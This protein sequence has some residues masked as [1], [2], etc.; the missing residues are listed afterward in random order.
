MNEENALIIPL[1]DKTV[2]GEF[3]A[4]LLGQRRSIE[5]RF[6]NLTFNIDMNWL[7]NLD[8]IISQRLS[9]Q[10][11]AKLV[12]FN[13]RFFFDSGK[14][15]TLNDEASF[16]S[17][18]D[19]SNEIAVGLD[20]RWAY[21]VKFPTSKLP[22][23][24]E[25]RFSAFTDNRVVSRNPK[26]EF[27]SFIDFADSKREELF[28]SIQFT[29][30][31]WGE[32]ISAHISNYIRS[33]TIEM[34]KWKTIVRQIRPI[35]AFMAAIVGMLTYLIISIISPLQMMQNKLLERYGAFNDLPTKLSTN[36]DKINFLVDVAI[37]RLKT[38]IIPFQFAFGNVFL[39]G[40]ILLLAV[41]LIFLKRRSFICINQHSKNHL[42]QYGKN[43]DLVWFGVCFTMIIGIASGVFGNKL[44]DLVK[45]HF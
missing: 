21:L 38:E 32:D 16:K 22:E 43:F 14:I 34:P 42:E 19:I 31:T 11:E 6:E 1:T 28:F 9:S 5:Q 37:I 25:I 17:F 20:L 30:V 24:Q 13:A 27:Y 23:K 8:A 26:K 40:V 4:G 2:L 12:S 3:I 36:D 35:F 10:N 15:L 29:N 18:H 45:H 41:V 39:Y 44:Y 33:K 7:H